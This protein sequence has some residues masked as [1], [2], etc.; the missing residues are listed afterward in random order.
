MDLAGKDLELQLMKGYS[1]LAYEPSQ[2]HPEIS[3]EK[4]SSFSVLKHIN[5]TE[6]YQS[7]NCLSGKFKKKKVESKKLHEAS[8]W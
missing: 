6:I 4:M 3:Q 7:F 5:S 2:Q 8:D 1:L